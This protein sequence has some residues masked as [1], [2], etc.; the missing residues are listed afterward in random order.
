[1]EDLNKTM[2]HISCAIRGGKDVVRN[3]TSLILARANK[4][5]EAKTL[6]KKHIEDSNRIINDFKENK[7]NIWEAIEFLHVCEQF[8]V[9][10]ATGTKSA[11]LTLSVAFSKYTRAIRIWDSPD[12]TIDTDLLKHAVLFINLA[13]AVK[14]KF[15]KDDHEAIVRAKIKD[16]EAYLDQQ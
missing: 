12:E 7:D 8:T 11:R 16:I 15:D 5:Q 6:L 10:K 2:N 9:V 3:A 1:M 4:N 14:L 13:D